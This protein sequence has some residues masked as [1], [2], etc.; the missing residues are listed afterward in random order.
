MSPKGPTEAQKKVLEFIREEVRKRGL[1]PTIREIGKRF[2]FRSTGTV[3]DHL[4]ALEQKGYLRRTQNRSRGI[5]LDPKLKED[6]VPI[7]GRVA[8]GLPILAEENLEGH[9]DLNE[10]LHARDAEHFALRVQGDSMMG[11]GIMEGDYVIVHSKD[12]AEFGEIVVALVDG[13]V[14]VKRLKPGKGKEAPLLV[15][16]NPAYKPIP[17]TEETRILGTVV[18]LLRNYSME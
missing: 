3:R 4:R 18:S 13:Q 2:G 5:E 14:T 6:R 9:I 15:P 12:T 16:E 7:L 17:V 1:P 10:V 8:A 11:A